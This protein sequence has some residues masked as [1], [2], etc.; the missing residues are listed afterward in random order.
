MKSNTD[1]NK[2]FCGIPIA[3]KQATPEGLYE[4]YVSKSQFFS[5]SV[6][7]YYSKSPHFLLEVFNSSECIG[8][9]I[10]KII[11]A[12]SLEKLEHLYNNYMKERNG[13]NKEAFSNG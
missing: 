9:N 6:R 13:L 5:V 4:Y 2:V 10:I 8:E 12:S 3:R 7:C 1:T 11:S